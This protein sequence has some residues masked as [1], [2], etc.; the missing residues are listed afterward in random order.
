MENMSNGAES[1]PD[2]TQRCPEW[3]ISFCKTLQGI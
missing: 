3:E 2:E 1:F